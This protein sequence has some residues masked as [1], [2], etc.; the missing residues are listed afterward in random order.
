MTDS[1]FPK[2]VYFIPDLQVKSLIAF[3]TPVPY[4]PTTPK[5]KASYGFYATE[6]D[7][8]R[9][10]R[11]NP[12]SNVVTIN[13]EVWAHAR[14]DAYLSAFFDLEDDMQSAPG[15][16]VEGHVHLADVT[17]EEVLEALAQREH[18]RVEAY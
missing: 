10:F 16:T 18:F 4:V 5:P 6:P 13:G 1:F 15:K 11:E 3:E 8:D 17:V 14:V 9:I 7:V 2:T 12:G